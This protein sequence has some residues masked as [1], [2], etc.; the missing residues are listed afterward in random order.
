M[1]YPLYRSARFEYTTGK[2][3]AILIAVL[4]WTTFNWR[5]PF[6]RFMILYAFSSHWI[7]LN[8]LLL[9]LLQRFFIHNSVAVYPLRPW[10]SARWPAIDLTIQA[11]K[12]TQLKYTLIFNHT[13][14]NAAIHSLMKTTSFPSNFSKWT[15][16]R[17]PL[18]SPGK[19][20]CGSN[21]P[22]HPCK[23]QIPHPR[24]GL[25]HSEARTA[26]ECSWISRGGC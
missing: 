1:R 20:T 3:I 15:T 26:V 5:I 22:A 21:S 2:E 9:Y 7:P 17:I 18:E 23:V 11:F 13:F 16:R 25:P 8:V 12:M 10:L 24:E 19:V 14:N 4:F 6:D